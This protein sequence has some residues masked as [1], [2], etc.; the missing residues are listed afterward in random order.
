MF[1]VECTWWMWVLTIK[2]FQLCCIFAN[3]HTKVLENINTHPVNPALCRKYFL[4]SELKSSKPTPVHLNL[5]GFSPS[6]FFRL[7]FNYLFLP[8][9]PARIQEI[10][11]SRH[12]VWFIFVT[13]EPRTG[14]RTNWSP[15]WWPGKWPQNLEQGP[16]QTDP[17]YD[18]GTTEERIN[19]AIQE[20]KKQTKA[21]WFYI[22]PMETANNR[23][24][25]GDKKT[26]RNPNDKGPVRARARRFAKRMRAV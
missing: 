7:D 15:I 21:D 10:L 24:G 26:K 6:V 9:P 20:R 8:L 25:L 1:M 22:S 13:S 11:E 4:K 2:F 18:P 12:H 23:T 3:F 14:P 19:E 16:E 5:L 17:P